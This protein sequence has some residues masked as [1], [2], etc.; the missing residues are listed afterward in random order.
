M[1]GTETH[2]PLAQIYRADFEDTII[3]GTLSSTLKKKINFFLQRKSLTVLP[4]RIP[5]II[6]NLFFDVFYAW[7][8][9]MICFR[10]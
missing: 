6:D 3:M 4:A 8:Y 7:M 2:S 1:S 10:N 5:S 9:A